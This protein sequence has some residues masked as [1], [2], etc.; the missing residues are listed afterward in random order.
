MMIRKPVRS[1]YDCDSIV[2][3]QLHMFDLSKL[4]CPAV[5]CRPFKN[6]TR[7]ISTA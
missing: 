5:T 7:M 1:L 2:R 6:Y 4:T 3:Y